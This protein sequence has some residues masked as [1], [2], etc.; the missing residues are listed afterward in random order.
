[1]ANILKFIVFLA[2]VIA[3]GTFAVNFYFGNL[4][5]PPGGF[6]VSTDAG[7]TWKKTGLLDAGGNINRLDVLDIV[8]NPK[9]S[10]ILYA[11]TMSGILK[12]VDG[13]EV[14]HRLEDK[15]KVLSPRANVFDL[16]ADPRF[17]DY[18]KNVPDQFYLAVYQND[19]G[20]VLKTKDGGVSFKEVY[21][22]SRA[23]V[24]V[25]DVAVD[26]NR[27][28]IVW[29]ATGEGTLLK[30]QDYG[31]TWRLV[32]EFGRPINYLIINPRNT[33]Q[34]LV[35]TFSGGIFTSPDGGATWVDDSEGLKSFTQARYIENLVYNPAD[36]FVY[37]AS[38]FGLLRSADFGLAWQAVDIIFP[39][40]VLPITDI[41]WGGAG[42]RNVY[43]SA[44]NF[45]YASQ[46]GGKFWQVRKLGA[47]KKIRALW[48][49]P[50]DPHKVIAGAG[51][52]GKSLNQRSLLVLPH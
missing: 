25:F 28:N 46:D 9:D 44:G 16:A 7:A 34:M 1:M 12:S 43:V 45:I 50:E 26:S 39:N 24:A 48:V 13:G 6:F 40:D 19:Y 32:Q 29:L 37:L 35:T 36:G 8:S 47:S 10:R 15:N 31:E 42:S 14:W 27:P 4:L 18:K 2:I 33:G 21:I 20:R 17:P 3:I 23:K 11:S 52:A 5:T 22:T 51:S 38:R 30:S 41:A 49:D